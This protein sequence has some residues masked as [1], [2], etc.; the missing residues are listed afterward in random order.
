MYLHVYN[1][2]M[3]G[4][5]KNFTTT[6]PEGILVAIGNAA[7]D[8]KL[9]KNDIIVESFLQWNKARKQ[10]LVRESYAKAKDDGEWQALAEM[11]IGDV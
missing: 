9:N 7:E 3:N 8:L 6:L 10:E 2:S 5:S 11:G 1:A 4:K